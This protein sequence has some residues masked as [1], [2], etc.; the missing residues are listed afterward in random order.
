MMLIGQVF[1][2][3][4]DLFVVSVSLFVVIWSYGEERNKLSSIA[5]STTCEMIWIQSLL[6]EIVITFPLAYGDIL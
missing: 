4:G 6:M 2:R 5:C 1:L 3:V